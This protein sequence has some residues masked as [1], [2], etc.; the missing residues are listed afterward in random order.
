M[1]V[2]VRSNNKNPRREMCGWVYPR[3][4]DCHERL[5]PM[6]LRASLDAVL[7]KQC[8]KCGVNQP[9]NQFYPRY[10][11]CKKCVYELNRIWRVA[12][13]DKVRKY[14]KQWKLMHREDV[15][16][17]KHNHGIRHREDRKLKQRWVRATKREAYLARETVKRALKKGDLIRPLYCK[18]CEEQRFIVAHH[19]NYKNQLEVHWL[20]NTC[21]Q[22]SHPGKPHVL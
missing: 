11:I 15:N 7:K 2:L 5:L 14:R 17:L 20:C 1:H 9:T 22:L 3:A 6:T 13:P 16:R 21:H 19:S 12:N 4:F 8:H 18:A 10:S